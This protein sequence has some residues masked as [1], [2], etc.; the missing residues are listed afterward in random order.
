MD[1]ATDS[2]RAGHSVFNGADL[3]PKVFGEDKVY[4]NDDDE[5]WSGAEVVRQRLRI[6][7]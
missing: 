5:D 6:Q 2:T 7:K 3:R 1:V 4:F